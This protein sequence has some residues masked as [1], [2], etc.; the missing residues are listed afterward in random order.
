MRVHIRANL[1][2][3]QGKKG[4]DKDFEH[5]RFRQRKTPATQIRSTRLQV[6][7]INND[8]KMKHIIAGEYQIFCYFTRVMAPHPQTGSNSRLLYCIAILLVILIA[9]IGWSSIQNATNITLPSSSSSSSSPSSSSEKS[10]NGNSA[11]SLRSEDKFKP[12][13]LP[14]ISSQP[15]Q[16]ETKSYLYKKSPPAMPSVRISEEE[17]KRLKKNPDSIYGGKG[18]KPHLGKFSASLSPPS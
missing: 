13:P 6:L 15:N 10:G 4:N 1:R 2:K 12:L 3:N 17:E 14:F 5:S 11:P 8:T 18:D 9:Q 16:F 7:H